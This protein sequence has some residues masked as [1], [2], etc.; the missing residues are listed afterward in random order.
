MAEI[1]LGSNGGVAEG[2]VLPLYDGATQTDRIKYDQAAQTTARYWWLRGPGPWGA[3][4]VRIV[5][6]SG[7]LNN[8]N[9]VYGNG[10]AAACVIY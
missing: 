4:G 1:G 10:M 7:V 2:S 3:R 8:D 9:A 5:N 6:P